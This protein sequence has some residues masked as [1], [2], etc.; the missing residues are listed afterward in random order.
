M[1]RQV[2]DRVDAVLDG[3]REGVLGR[4]AV[5]DADDH[6]VHLVHDRPRPPCVIV[7]RA[8]REATAVEVHH[9]GVSL[10]LLLLVHAVVLRDVE[11]QVEAP[12][13]RR[14]CCAY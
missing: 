7:R 1:A 4:E 9:H 3:R 10:V 11:L 14:Y 5:V 6:G 2:Q 13:V 8:Q 12:F